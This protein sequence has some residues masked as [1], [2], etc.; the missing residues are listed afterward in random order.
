MNILGL[1]RMA[2]MMRESIAKVMFGS[3]GL[4]VRMILLNRKNQT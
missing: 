4:W 1:N 3:F 2:A